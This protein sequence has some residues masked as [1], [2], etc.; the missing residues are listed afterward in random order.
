[1]EKFVFDQEIFRQKFVNSDG[2][3]N[4]AK[5]N[6]PGLDSI[7][8]VDSNK[9]NTY[10]GYKSGELLADSLHNILGMVFDVREDRNIK[11]DLFNTIGN[12]IS[13]ET[14]DL[15]DVFMDLMK[16]MYFESNVENN[17]NGLALLRYQ[18]A[19]RQKDFG[20]LVVDVLMDDQTKKRLLEILESDS[21]PL[22][23]IVNQAYLEL[24]ILKNLKQD[25]E[26]IPV[27][28]EELADL[29][30]VMNMDFR[31]ALDS[32]TDTQAEIG[33]LLSYYLFIYLSQIAIRLDNDLADMKS[34]NTFPYFKG[35]REAVSEDRDC[36]AHGWRMIERKTRK[37]FKHLVVL[38][39]LNCHDHSVPYYSYS[40]LFEMYDKFPEQRADMDQA[41]DY[42]IRQYT[43][44]YRHLSDIPGENI[45]FSGIILE[46]TGEPSADYQAKVKYLYE[47]VSCQLDGKKSR[48]AV[49]SYVASN[50]N[51]ILKMRFVKR[52]G[53]MGHMMMI[54]NDDL[55]LMIQ[56]C[57]RSSVKTDPERGIPIRDLFEEFNRR[58]LCM[59]GK[60]RQYIIDYLIDINLIDSKCDSEEAQYVR[61]IQ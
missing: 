37:V 55:V 12:M 4:K 47:C 19:S 7:C 34:E 45:D 2:I 46:Q 21:N 59:D 22:D 10:Q 49:V 27:F 15:K 28:K 24:N 8:P 25:I 53:Q 17:T 1:M 48:V 50:Y 61:R 5:N 58:G 14:D 3:R 30:T 33:F 41:V 13:Y 43:K 54:S 42:L 60:T 39:M 18:P 32:Q 16:S 51:H 40:D 36:V 11:E 26:Y 31:S 9:K 57:Q 56:I 52:W 20:K 23:E 29:F 44:E 38:N 6:Q 35:A